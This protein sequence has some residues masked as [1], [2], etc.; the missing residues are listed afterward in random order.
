MDFILSYRRL[1]S[2]TSIPSSSDIR[3][4]IRSGRTDHSVAYAGIHNDPSDHHSDYSYRTSYQAN[5]H[6]TYIQ[7]MPKRLNQEVK[8]TFYYSLRFYLSE[9]W[10]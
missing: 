5:W 2:K 8:A 7:P 9:K 3:N 1:L 4:A 10:T 6:T